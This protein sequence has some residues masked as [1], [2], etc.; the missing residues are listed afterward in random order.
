MKPDLNST[1]ASVESGNLKKEVLVRQAIWALN[2]FSALSILLFCWFCIET[3]GWLILLALVMAA[4]S[5]AIT[6]FLHYLGKGLI[7]RR[8]TI[9]WIAVFLLFSHLALGYREGVW[10]G[11]RFDDRIGWLPKEN[12]NQV[13]L[14]GPAGT[15]Y[16]VTT[17]NQGYRNQ[18]KWPNKGEVLPVLLQGDSNAFGFGLQENE[19]FCRLWEKRLGGSELCYNV[20]VP[21]YDPQHYYFQYEN[22]ESRYQI[23]KRII[24]F[25]VGNDFTMS[26]FDSPYLIRRPY[27]YVENGETKSYIPPPAKFRKQIYG[28]YFIKPYE[29]FNQEVS[30]VSAGR[31]WGRFV[32]D[33]LAEF[34]LGAFLF[35]MIY[36]RA[37]KIYAQTSLSEEERSRH[38]ALNPYYPSWQQ[39]DMTVWPD[40]YKD[41]RAHFSALLKE[42][43][44]Q[45]AKSTVL[46]MFPMRE[47]VLANERDSAVASHPKFQV[48]AINSY[49]A[50]L[51]RELGITVL[52]STPLFL[53]HPTPQ[54]LFQADQ[55]L[56]SEGMSLVVD[57]AISSTKVEAR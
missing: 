29:N 55:H 31:D 13:S 23:N 14:E 30:L 54:R 26:A 16:L 44:K 1:E 49:V 52:D 17:D 22:F 40:P 41:F 25:N 3:E 2:I 8:C 56:S 28:H 5:L 47:Q 51:A 11:F 38:R 39:L 53:S 36:P 18:N 48:N 19:T 15:R 21:G 20:G 45:Q 32:P 12:L 4:L 9:S 57:F 42:T 33:W 7:A 34:R 10:Q 46:I 50:G 27:L 43:S 35:E 6:R 24:L 37:F